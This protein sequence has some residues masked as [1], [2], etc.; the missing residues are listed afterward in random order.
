VW[1]ATAPVYEDNCP[2]D[3]PNTQRTIKG[4]AQ[5]TVR[6]PNPP[7]DSTVTATVDCNWTAIVARGGGGTFGNLKGTI[8]SLVE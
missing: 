4:F 6:M 3:N 2:C 5:V 8:P 1:T 7:P